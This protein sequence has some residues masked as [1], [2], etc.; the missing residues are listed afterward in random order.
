MVAA[1]GLLLVQ[2][3]YY[4]RL[5]FFVA[6]FFIGLVGEV[7]RMLEISVLVYM[8]IFGVFRASLV[9]RIDDGS[10]RPD[11][12]MCVHQVSSFQVRC[13]SCEKKAPL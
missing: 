6:N 2:Q 7:M 1:S 11:V 4:G 13:R 12:I 3:A 8:F 9:L 5:G 10:E